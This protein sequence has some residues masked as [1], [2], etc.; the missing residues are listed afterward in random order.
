MRTAHVIRHL[1]IQILLK[2]FIQYNINIH[3]LKMP[4]DDNEED[5]CGVVLSRAKREK[6]EVL[7]A[8]K[9]AGAP[10]GMNDLDIQYFFPLN[11]YPTIEHVLR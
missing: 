4:D 11:L 2:T 10:P 3:L 1:N 8:N 5:Y 7:V 6:I 9:E